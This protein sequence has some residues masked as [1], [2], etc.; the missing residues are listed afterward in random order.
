MTFKSA[1]LPSFKVIRALFTCVRIREIR[2]RKDCEIYVWCRLQ[3]DPG[4]RG[5]SHPLW[6]DANALRNSPYPLCRGQ[7]KFK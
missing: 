3:F 1:R 2:C 4:T 6:G 7:I 5:L